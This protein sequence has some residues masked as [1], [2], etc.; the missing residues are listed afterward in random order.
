MLVSMVAAFFV[1]LILRKD[2]IAAVSWEEWWTYDG[3]SGPAFWGLINP[4]WSLCNKGRRQSPVNLEPSK[5]LFDPNLRTLHIDK[6]RVNG[7]IMNT[8][9]SVIFTVDND[10]RHHINV[11]GGPLSYKYQFQEIHIHYGLH[12]QFGSEHSINGYA[13]PAELQI[14]GF[15][16]QLYS[17]FTEALHKAQGIVVISL[18][19]QLG[20]LSNAELRLLTDKLDRIRYGGE[21]VEVKR[22]SVR[23]LL[24]ETDYYMTYDGS[25]T[26]PAC[27]E[28]ATWLLLNMTIIHDKLLTKSLIRLISCVINIVEQVDT[29]NGKQCPSMYKDVHYKANSWRQH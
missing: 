19:L 7:A 14:F 5:L 12:D 20:D 6:H 28:T 17:N 22:L 16:S 15:N 29:L 4:E 13:F 24:P 21:E 1:Q 11:T 26:M 2:I 3:I 23:G 27:Y 9:H 18:L 8:G 25:T 10:T